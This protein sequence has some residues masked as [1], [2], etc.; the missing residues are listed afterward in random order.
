MGCWK[1]SSIDRELHVLE[2]HVSNVIMA[3]MV[4]KCVGQC[5]NHIGLKYVKLG[6]VSLRD[7]LF[8]AKKLACW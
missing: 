8:G 5:K 3:I 7:I 2:V 4:L 6:G 1:E